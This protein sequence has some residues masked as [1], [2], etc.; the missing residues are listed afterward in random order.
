MNNQDCWRARESA[1]T[2]NHVIY[3]SCAG[4]YNGDEGDQHCFGGPLFNQQH[5]CALCRQTD[6]FVLMH[7][8]A[9]LR[10]D[11]LDI[12]MLCG[13]CIVKALLTTELHSTPFLPQRLVKPVVTCLL[14]MTLLQEIQ[15]IITT[16]DP[17][18][19]VIGKW[20]WSFEVGRTVQLRDR[21]APKSQNKNRWAPR[22]AN[23]HR[24]PQ[25]SARIP[26]I[27]SPG[28]FDAIAATRPTR[29]LVHGASRHRAVIRV[30]I[31]SVDHGASRGGG[32]GIQIQIDKALFSTHSKHAS[33]SPRQEDGS[34]RETR[35]SSS[36][37]AS[38]RS[39]NESL[40]PRP[41]PSAPG[42]P[43]RGAKRRI[44]YTHDVGL[45]IK[46]KNDN[47]CIFYVL[48]AFFCR[49]YMRVYRVYCPNLG[50]AP[51]E[52][53]FANYYACPSFSPCI[54]ATTQW[55]AKC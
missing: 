24:I 51:F 11:N 13:D 29:G 2:P 46:V 53:V 21:S 42:T 49:V 50:V 35:S 54:F 19:H 10:P 48:G 20:T 18:S 22:G 37:T 8:C 43:S 4:Q 17:D 38:S 30:R 45:M 26:T 12:D 40:M 9:E 36:C 47:R 55:K 25:R 14:G 41:S 32:D 16:I 27:A 52:N 31:P 1:Q 6:N 28:A 44:P 34:E 15:N 33:V 23:V 3:A 5:M 39:S 7:V